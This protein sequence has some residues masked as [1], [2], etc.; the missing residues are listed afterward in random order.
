M[1]AILA[2]VIVAAVVAAGAFFW[3]K[4]D[5]APAGSVAASPGVT[6]STPMGQSKD[7]DDPIEKMFRRGLYPEAIAAWEKEAARGNAQAA[8]RLGVEYQ[9]GK[10][11]VAQRDYAKAMQYHK[12]A[13]MAG[14]ALSMFD[15]GSM[16]EYGFGIEKN[17]AEAA[18]WYGYSARYGLAQGQYNYATML[19]RGDG[20]VADEVEAYKFFV[21]AARGGFTG[22]PYDSQRYRVDQKAPT[23]AEEMQ[24]RLTAA[25]VA[26]GRA[27]A[28]VFKAQTGPL[29]I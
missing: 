28:D 23:P 6:M 11:G 9:D 10:P 13:A 1:R 18:R 15:L 8:H 22:I 4:R 3:L 16:Y 21:L 17:M 12:Q 5:G 7:P 20:V 25:Q 24:R 27:R 29:S 2:L 19:E 26:E 14:N